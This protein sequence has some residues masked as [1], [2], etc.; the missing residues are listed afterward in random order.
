[1]KIIFLGDPI[2]D[3]YIWGT[4]ER[5]S[6]E[7]PVPILK[8]FKKESRL[9]GAANCLMN[10]LA[11]GIEVEY[12]FFS[13]KKDKNISLFKKLIS[14]SD[15]VKIIEIPAP[16]I[17]IPIKSRF[18]GNGQQ[19]LRVDEEK[20]VDPPLESISN[21]ERYLN[22]INKDTL[23]VISDY[24]KGYLP[25]S[26]I[27]LIA[28]KASETNFKYMVDPHP[29]NLSYFKNAICMTPNAKEASS[30]LN[31]K[32]DIQNSMKALDTMRQKTNCYFP[33]ITMGD[34]GCVA[35]SEK[36]YIHL[37]TEAKQVF[38]VTGAGDTF[39]ASLVAAYLYKQN[40]HKSL[41][42][43]NYFAGKAVSQIG[44]YVINKEDIK[45]IL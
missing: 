41:P 15:L 40:I 35:L 45:K 3:Q 7:A 8:T 43:A 39:F 12:I 6:P 2:I 21:L 36:D 27:K 26:I 16:D 18:I 44:A 5:I 38:D 24:N 19:L 42:I 4:A 34:S 23:I 33:C 11:F 28:S 29:E 22:K 9:G 1:M 10:I 32:V 31:F 13:D 14:N 20:R 25:I 37:Q 30:F 17:R